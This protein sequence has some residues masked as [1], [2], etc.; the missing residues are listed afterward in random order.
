MED[1]FAPC[2]AMLPLVSTR[3]IPSRDICPSAARLGARD[4]PASWQ[5]AQCWWY[6]PSPLS[7][8]EPCCRAP[9]AITQ[10]KSET[11][12]S[13]APLR[14]QILAVRRG[15]PRS[16]RQR[17]CQLQLLRHPNYWP[18]FTIAQWNSRPL[19][20]VDDGKATILSREPA[21]AEVAAVYM[22][23]SPHYIGISSDRLAEAGRGREV[24]SRPA[25]RGN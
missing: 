17:I 3:R 24:F 8:A 5:L 16:H 10:A 19:C 9:A 6:S 22:R 15:S 23:H 12:T 1:R 20:I 14:M 2:C 7:P 13:T 18:Q 21:L 4:I 25:V 11:P